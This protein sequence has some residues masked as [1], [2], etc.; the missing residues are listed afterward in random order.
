MVPGTHVGSWNPQK[1]V[2]LFTPFLH[3]FQFLTYFQHWRSWTGILEL[4]FFV[5][6]TWK[7]FLL[8]FYI[9]NMR[10]FHFWTGYTL[11]CCTRSHLFFGPLIECNERY[12]LY[13]HS[14]HQFYLAI[15]W[16]N[17]GTE[18]LHKLFVLGPF[19]NIRP[20]KAWKSLIPFY[21]FTPCEFRSLCTSSVVL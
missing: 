13:Y 21:Q 5:I 3:V 16:I 7:S 15:P 10:D 9:G 2:G 8:P 19:Y 6:F 11:F 12:F 1:N 14:F 20:N 4:I 17:F 18:V